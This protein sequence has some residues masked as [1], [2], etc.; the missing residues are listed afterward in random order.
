MEG[1]KEVLRKRWRNSRDD[2]CLMDKPTEI[3]IDTIPDASFVSSLSVRS[4]V[5]QYQCVNC[6]APKTF[7][8][9][10]CTNS[11]LR[12]TDYKFK[13]NGR[14]RSCIQLRHIILI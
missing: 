12:Y 1:F 11:S 4:T 13:Q 14:K 7:R 9:I 5:V 8:T 2:P 3:E 6:F 10:T